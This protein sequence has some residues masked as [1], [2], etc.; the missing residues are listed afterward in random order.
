MSMFNFQDNQQ[1]EEECEMCNYLN[2]RL[3]EALG[4]D[5]E[6]ELLDIISDVFQDAWTIGYTE[7]LEHSTKVNQA[8][9]DEAMSPYGYENEDYEDEYSV[10]HD[11]YSIE[12]KTQK[13]DDDGE[14]GGSG[15]WDDRLR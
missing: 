9:I 12:I 11:N 6:D 8:L 2:R 7:A 15:K 13:I 10:N 1:P 14:W 5:S 4:S 3:Q